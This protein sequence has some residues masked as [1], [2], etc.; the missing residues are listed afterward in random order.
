MLTGCISTRHVQPV[1]DRAIKQVIAAAP[2]EFEMARQS[3]LAM[4]GEYQ[5][6]FSFAETE[7][8]QPDYK[9]KKHRESD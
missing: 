4:A 9:L 8:V 1:D 3:I 2:T 7:A 6:T 5:V